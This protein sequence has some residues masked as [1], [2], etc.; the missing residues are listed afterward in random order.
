MA[1]FWDIVPCNLHG[2]TFQKTSSVYNNMRACVGSIEHFPKDARLIIDKT[3][4]EKIR[5]K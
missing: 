1:V 4:N 5:K 2:A 3:V